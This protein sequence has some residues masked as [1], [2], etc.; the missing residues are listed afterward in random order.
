MNIVLLLS[1]VHCNIICIN[2]ANFCIRS[3]EFSFSNPIKIAYQKLLV[4]KFC[5]ERPGHQFSFRIGCV[6]DYVRNIGDFLTGF[7]L[8]PLY[9]YKTGSKVPKR[10]ELATSND[11]PIKKLP[12]LS[13]QSFET[14]TSWSEIFYRKI[15]I[16]TLM[17]LQYKTKLNVK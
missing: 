6:N 2:L 11:K 12:L 14:D 4:P 8:V 16:L 9:R 10:C 17:N 7:T 1:I 13:I 3:I 5:M 15:N